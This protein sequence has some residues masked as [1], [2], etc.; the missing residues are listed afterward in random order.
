MT[1]ALDGLFV[2]A[3]MAEFCASGSLPG[4][5]PPTRP[6][7]PPC[8]AAEQGLRRAYAV[9]TLV[10]RRRVVAIMTISNVSERD[11]DRQVV[12]HDSPV[13]VA[14]RAS[15]CVPSQQLAPMIDGVAARHDGQLKVVAV[16]VD[17][18]PTDNKIC[19][20]FQVTRLPVVLLF[21]DGRVVDAIGGV[22]SQDNI[23]EMADRQLRPVMDVDEFTFD[24]EVL[25]SKIPVLVHVDAAWCQASQALLPVVESAAE[26]FRGRT[27]VVRLG[28]GPE[29]ARVCAEFGF[30]RVPTLALFQQGRIED[31]ILGGMEGGTKTEAVRTSCVGLTGEDNIFQM[32]DRFVL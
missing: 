27:K 25:K 12:Q 11:F 17:G 6:R 23:D 26:Q 10:A 18:S 29:T 5:P 2:L 15:W 24:T 30:R 14:F 7:Q 1:A 8:R 13:M 4:Q 20:R 22:A 9:V 28:F 16:D 19:R 21:R 31:Q 32:V 3:A